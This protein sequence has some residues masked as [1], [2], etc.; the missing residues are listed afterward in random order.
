MSVHDV[1]RRIGSLTYTMRHGWFELQAQ[2]AERRVWLL[3]IETLRSPE[4]LT[5]LIDDGRSW[6]K[7]SYHLAGKEDGKAAALDAA[8]I[9]KLSGSIIEQVN[10]DSTHR[11][12]SIYVEIATSLGLECGAH[13]THADWSH[14]QLQ[15]RR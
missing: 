6:S 15:R 14:V 11:H 13:W 12:W 8:P 2:A 9:V 7:R 4:R 3:L 5:W 1:D 10:W